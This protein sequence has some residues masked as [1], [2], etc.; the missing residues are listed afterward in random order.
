MKLTPES[1]QEF[2][3]AYL[4]DF[5]HEIGLHEAERLGQ[6]LINILSIVFYQNEN[7]K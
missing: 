6:S 1:I 4:Q 7:G 3:A 5:G 2:Q